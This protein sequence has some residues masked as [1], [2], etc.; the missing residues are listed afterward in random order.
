LGGAFTWIPEGIYFTL[1]NKT[2]RPLY[3][4]NPKTGDHSVFLSSPDQIFNVSFSKS[5]QFAVNAKAGDKLNEIYASSLANPK[6]CQSDTII[7]PAPV[8]QR[9]GPVC[10]G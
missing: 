1:W 7:T 2:N 5:G 6:L 10:G 8:E 9:P 4:I 3:K